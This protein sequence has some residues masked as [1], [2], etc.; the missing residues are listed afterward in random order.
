MDKPFVSVII[1]VYND[2]RRLRRCL[3]ALHSQSYPLDKYEIIVVDNNSDVDIRDWVKQFPLG[4]FFSEK[5]IGSYAARNKGIS[6]ARGPIIGFT[7]SDCIPRPDWIEKGVQYFF[8]NEYRGF[9]AGNVTLTFR[10]KESLTAVEIFEK[11]QAFNIKRKLE[12]YQHGV[13]ANLF[14]G[15]SII[16]RV[17]AFD[18]KL[19]SGGDVEWC[20]RVFRD[21]YQPIYAEDLCVEHPARS[22]WKNL[23]NKTA[24]VVGGIRDLNHTTGQEYGYEGLMK[25]LFRL[26]FSLLGLIKRYF[27]SQP[28]SDKL[29][30]WEQKMKFFGAKGF[31]GVVRIYE[32]I[33]LSRG[34]DS[35][36]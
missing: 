13:T 27:L 2:E 9:I 1:P 3:R 32:K 25:D 4:K 30:G 15:Q 35:L 18:E 28:P 34:G 16:R 7:D 21:G 20:R 10:R 24:R 11:I 31:V 19:K 12:V 6:V 14:S 5:K 22:T 29:E 36:R 33:R 17:G 8:L 26:T 23:K